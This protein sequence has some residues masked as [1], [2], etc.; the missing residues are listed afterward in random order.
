MWQ[1]IF[2][3]LSVFSEKWPVVCGAV[4]VV[5]LA[6]SAN[7]L[8]FRTGIDKVGRK[9]PLLLLVV[10]FLFSVSVRL[11]FIKELFVP[12]YFD[13]VE[14][15]RISKELVT[16][17]ETST[18]LET[19]PTLT[20]TY[21]HL[22][23]HFLASFLTFGLRANP[24][25]VILVLGQVILAAI[26]VPVFFLIRQ[27]THS[28][29]AAFFGMLLAGFGWY[30]P[31]FA[32][33]WGKYPALAG[34]LALGT[35][36]GIACWISKEKPDRNPLIAIC[37]L[38]LGTLV[39]TFFHSRTLV[40]IAVSIASWFVAGR[41][42]SLSKILRYITLGILIFGI[43][44]FGLCIQ[45][46]PL[47]KLTL[48]PYLEDGLNVTLTVMILS[49]FAL[50]KFPRAVYF[51]ILFIFSTFV[52]LFVPIG[53]W[54]P[55]IENQTL[56]D[57][58]FV[59]MVLYLPLSMLGGLGLAGLLQCMT[60]ITALS[61]KMRLYTR[62]LSALLFLG[63]AVWIPLVTYN[64]YPSDCCQ[65]VGYDDTVALDW[66]N[67]NLPPAAHILI[68]G[69]QLS[70]LP[71]GPSTNLVGTDAGIWIPALTGRKATLA[72]SD[73]DFR[74][75]STLEQLCQG[76]IDYVYVGGTDQTFDA[77]QLNEKAGWYERILSLPSAQ[78]YRLKGCSQ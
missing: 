55:G 74:S 38:T 14:H 69:R 20:P 50:I 6:C 48:E 39:S 56:L 4:I 11:A 8:L 66:S 41:M 27:A 3:G 16:S 52:A 51:C 59:E 60:S 42:R 71:S 45:K 62:V 23:F 73:I 24:M 25:D 12:P 70:V 19:I 32:V 68:A 77:T 26:P 33:N 1:V 49:L 2:D 43:L 7:F 37:V 65:F 17:L 63:F 54:S 34:L 10:F 29:R 53:N 21:Y 44:I 78:L 61:E 36:L 15:Y 30:M 76:K 72:P 47:L 64:F 75:E 13:S 18:L 22:G 9:P 28:D 58:P 67:K 31:G 46:E 40:V 57:R 35:V 5:C